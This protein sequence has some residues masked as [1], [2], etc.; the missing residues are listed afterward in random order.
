[1]SSSRNR[2]RHGRPKHRGWRVQDGSFVQAGTILATQRTLR[3]HPGLNVG[4]GRDGTLFAI[5]SGKV[6]VTCEKV[7][8]NWEH[9]WVKKHYEGRNSQTFYKKYFNVIQEPQH[10]RFKLI[11][12]I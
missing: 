8:L 2:K 10:T 6:M 4:F 3:F 9:V 7:D 5:E 11:D 1:G 12:S